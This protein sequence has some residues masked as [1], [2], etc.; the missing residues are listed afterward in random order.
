MCL[1]GNYKFVT[2]CF[3]LTWRALHIGLLTAAETF[4]NTLSDLNKE[5]DRKGGEDKVLTE[6][7]GVNEMIYFRTLCVVSCITSVAA[8]LC[9][10][11]NL[12]KCAANFIS[13]LLCG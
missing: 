7:R 6:L 13:Q 8:A 3:F 2:E 9:W 11:L 10:I 12:F 1:G 4:L 5:I